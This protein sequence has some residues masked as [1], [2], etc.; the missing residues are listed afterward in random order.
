MKVDGQLESLKS[1]LDLLRM[2]LSIQE[3]FTLGG[4][5]AYF[6][7]KKKGYITAAD[8]KQADVQHSMDHLDDDDLHHILTPR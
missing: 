6:D 4:I 7:P 1:F 8:L 3:D 5:V 2:R